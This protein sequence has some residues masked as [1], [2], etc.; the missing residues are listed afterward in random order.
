MIVGIQPI[1]ARPPLQLLFADEGTA[2]YARNN[3]GA[4]LPSRTAVGSMLGGVLRARSS[5][6]VSATVC[7][8]DS[9]TLKQ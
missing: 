8:S 9:H 5:R 3:W 6:S 1:S 2:A 7:A 4:S